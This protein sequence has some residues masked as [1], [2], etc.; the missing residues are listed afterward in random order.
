[1]DKLTSKPESGPDPTSTPVNVNS[2]IMF[3]K[4][5]LAVAPKGSKGEL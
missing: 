2:R 3:R 4:A 1:M 5:K